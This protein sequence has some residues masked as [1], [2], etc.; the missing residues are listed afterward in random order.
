MRRPSLP[1]SRRRPD[2]LV[3]KYYAYQ[4]AMTFGFFS[5]IW[6]V[7]LLANDL[8]Y[9]QIAFLGSLSAGI[10]VVGEIPTGYVGDRFGRRSSLL[11][12]STLLAGSVYALAVVESYAGFVVIYSL[13]ALGGAF[14]SGAGDAW[15]Y[16]VLEERLDADAFTRVRGRG[17][18]VNLTVSAGSMLGAGAL[19]AVDPAL[20][21]WIAGTVN[22]AGVAVLLTMPT[23]DPSGGDDASDELGLRETAHVL[24]TELFAPHVRLV[25]V[26]VAL[27]VGATVTA[28]SF[29]QPVA[30]QDVGLSE[31][32]L[33]PLYTAF[34]LVA[35]TA[36]Y[37]ADR[38]ETVLGR[39][40]ALWA[41]PVVVGAV[42]VLPALTAPVVAL[43]AFFVLKASKQAIYPLASGFLNDHVDSVGR[44]TVLSAAS[45]CYASVRFVLKPLGGLVADALGPLSAVAVL[46]AFLVAALALTRGVA[47]LAPRLE[48][49]P[50]SA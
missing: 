23:V 32:A 3:A 2:P 15:L 21:F 13:W 14:R 16:D 42:L 18:A 46:G 19:Y 45:M 37:H 31:T 44:A 36:S 29:V 12:G 28:D 6:V 50:T 25:V 26:G 34:S 24:R 7:F 1:S 48:A 27:F 17:G 35:A 38:L 20:P 5:P 8:S 41:I 9:T 47:S 49:A 22:V 30:V 4:A 43:P 11:L 10:A 40:H 33:G 39:R